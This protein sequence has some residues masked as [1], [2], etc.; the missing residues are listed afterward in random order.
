M[1]QAHLFLYIIPQPCFLH[2][3][4]YDGVYLLFLCIS[5]CVVSADR[6]NQQ[7]LCCTE[8]FVYYAY[9]FKQLVK[10]E[11]IR[12]MI[13]LFSCLL[14]ALDDIPKIRLSS[15]SFYIIL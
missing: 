10:L 9:L 3:L 8:S 13:Q 14:N 6:C 12:K 2:H 7:K 15:Q 1:S 4:E 5:Q 11:F